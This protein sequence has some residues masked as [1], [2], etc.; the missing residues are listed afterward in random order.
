MKK[1]NTKLSISFISILETLL[2]FIKE[3]GA[4][5]LKDVIWSGSM[6]AYKSTRGECRT[7][8][9]LLVLSFSATV[10]ISW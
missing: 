6:A 3:S 10:L 1:Q 5:V 9:Y 8:L 2:D 7:Q 4:H